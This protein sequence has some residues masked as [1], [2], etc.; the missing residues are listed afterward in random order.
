[1]MGPKALPM[2]EVPAF[3]T[4][5]RPQMMR[6]VMMTT[7]LCPSPSRAWPTSMERRPSMA[8]VTVTAGVS[9]PSASSAAPPIMAG[10]MSHL[11]LRF[12]RL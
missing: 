4:K 6:I 12:T 2:L 8:V 11:A 7:L 5:N 1:M 3:C 9:T 10:T